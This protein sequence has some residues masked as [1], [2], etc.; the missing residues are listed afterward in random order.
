MSLR[1][2]DI[3]C[4]TRWLHRSCFHHPFCAPPSCLTT[5]AQPILRLRAVVLADLLTAPLVC[6]LHGLARHKRRPLH[7]LPVPERLWRTSISVASG[8][9]MSHIPWASE[10]PVAAL[11]TFRLFLFLVVCATDTYSHRLL[12][13][14]WVGIAARPTGTRLRLAQVRVPACQ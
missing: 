10:T 6:G 5:F 4:D 3:D 13:V 1:H 2:L 8:G 11:S 14:E 9:Q 7:V 12:V